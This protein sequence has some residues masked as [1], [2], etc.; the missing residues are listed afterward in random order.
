MRGY[1]TVKAQMYTN[2][3]TP[4]VGYLLKTFPKL[5]ET[6]ILN[7]IV[8]LEGMGSRLHLFSLRKPPL[9]DKFHPEVAEVQAKVTYI[10]P[11]SRLTRVGHFLRSNVRW[12]PLEATSAGGEHLRLFIHNPIRYLSTLWFH[13]RA[14]GKRRLKEFL[15]AGLVTRGLQRRKIGHL[16]AH[17]ANVPASVAELV[18]RFSGITFSFTAHA[19]DIY[20]T[21][22][23]ELTRKM[24]AAKFVL[25]CTGYNRK[26]LESI[27]SGCTPIYLAYHGVD[28]SR[29]RV[30]EAAPRPDG[31]LRLLSV[32]RFCEK[33]G[34]PYL[35]RACRILKERGWKFSCAIVG[36]GPTYD[37]LRSLIAELD[38]ASQVSLVPELTQ[39]QL[40]EMYRA[41]GIF[42]LP[43][44]LTSDGDRDGI[45]NVLIEA[46]AMQ[47]PVVSTDVSGIPE[48]VDHMQNGLLVPEKDVAAL[49]DA[50]ELLFSDPELRR[51]FGENGRAKV[52]RQFTLAHN[53]GI[54]QELL[55]AAAGAPPVRQE[56]SETVGDSTR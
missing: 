37:Q 51:R 42:V 19:K 31:P 53:V 16:H 20:L 18:H 55:L 44:I 48:L 46:M 11:L 17:F 41:A 28:L 3:Y 33:K 43:C 49:A 15:Q 8:Q 23:R 6:F 26:Y 54:I 50:I 21:S 13:L 30:L 9:Y 40:V 34:F 25:T 2:D 1:A 5:S 10:R 38:L 39:D 32:G 29:F 27:G 36:F 45:P 35:I 7:E 4:T 12:D 52:M 22:H 47:I 14:P 56:E 24:R